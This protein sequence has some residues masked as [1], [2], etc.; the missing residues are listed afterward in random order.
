MGRPVPATA[1][2]TPEE[3]TIQTVNELIFA[4]A[5][6]LASA[7]RRRQVSAVEV[8]E[9]HLAHIARHN[10][11]LNAIVT[12]DEEGAR[13]RARAADRALARDEAWGPLHGVPLTLKDCH[14]TAGMR[15]TCGFP[16]LADYVPAEDGTIAARLKA[17]GAIILGKTN[18]PVLLGSIR[19]DNPI[20]GRTNN[21][22]DLER[23][24]GGS[25]GG[26]G[27]ALAAGLTPLEIGSDLGG[28][29]R[30]PSHFC[31]VFGLKPTEHRVSTA[32]HIPEL[33]GTPRSVRYLAV[34]GPMAR[35]VDDLAQA[36]RIIAGGDGRDPDT[37]LAPLPVVDAP[38]PAL[39]E[40]RIAWTPAFPGAPV[41]SDIREAIE[42]LAAELA[43][44]GVQ[45]EERLPEV[46]FEEQDE[47]LYRLA[48][49]M[50]E[51]FQPGRESEPPF[52][53][54]D[55]LTALARRDDFIARWEAFYATWDALLCPAFTTT[56]FRH[57]DERDK[58]G[59]R[60]ANSAT[61]A[62]Q[63]AVTIPLAAD[64]D[65]L[66][67]GLQICGPR[68][69]D[70]RLLAIAAALAEVTGGFRRPPGY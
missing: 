3:E 52:T 57:E 18:V 33:P 44:L 47:L 24:P 56:A 31:G 51:V 15:T 63:P 35:T 36:F 21:P 22:W 8:V 46:D 10:P 65:G 43:R 45:I 5:T 48:D 28:S 41:A 20:F 39:R 32:G 29:I 68:W 25:S 70:E 50:T 42:G 1:R 49:Y 59:Y 34:I 60:C 6:E 53:L 4:T 61:L 13:Q 2:A 30:F 58:R 16:P 11:S 7:I 64:R 54:A 14:A 67:I 9:A 27:A 17:A 55:Y 26:A 66:P 69:S 12:L 37:D 23:T 62:G 19:T 38:R 40:L